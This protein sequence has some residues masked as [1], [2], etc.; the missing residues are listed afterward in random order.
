MNSINC[1]NCNNKSS[2]NSSFCTNCG[3]NLAVYRATLVKPTKVCPECTNDCNTADTTCKKCGY[4]FSYN[5]HSQTI[6]PPVHQTPSSL[7]QTNSKVCPECS[8]QN[9]I[10]S[11]TCFKCGFPFEN[12][13]QV[14]GTMPHPEVVATN[15]QIPEEKLNESKDSYAQSGNIDI[16]VDTSDN[17]VNQ[18]NPL[19]YILIGL[20][21]VA[22][23]ILA[24]A[25][26]SK[27]T[28]SD[29]EVG[30][31]VAETEVDESANSDTVLQSSTQDF[32]MKEKIFEWEELSAIQTNNGVIKYQGCEAITN[33]ED[34]NIYALVTLKSYTYNLLKFDGLVWSS[35]GNI[36]T[37]SELQGFDGFNKSIIAS[38]GHIYVTGFS[39]N[40][41]DEVILHWDGINW[42]IINNA[43]AANHVCEF[44]HFN[45]NQLRC[46]NGNL[47]SWGEFTNY[48]CASNYIAFRE[49]GD[50]WKP[51]IPLEKTPRN[52][53]GFEIDNNLQVYLCCRDDNSK[54]GGYHYSIYKWNGSDLINISS[55]FESLFHFK[56]WEPKTLPDGTG[57]F[58][59]DGVLYFF[60]ENNSP[61]EA[62][63]LLKWDGSKWIRVE[64]DNFSGFNSNIC[65][66]NSDYNGNVFVAGK[67]TNAS[68]NYYLAQ[69]NGSEWKEVGIDNQIKLK[70]EDYIFINSIGIDRNGF[71]Y[72]CKEYG[73]IYIAKTVGINQFSE[74]D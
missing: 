46:K 22:A 42:L 57:L 62:Y 5:L 19:K 20:A 32:A 25:Y 66:I 54:G 72:T 33:D 52:L 67:F 23:L 48:S 50:K 43:A 24:Y 27:T 26:Y 49:D 73:K 29:Q 6:V 1:P 40:E 12:K 70:K 41:R 58:Y 16:K 2:D 68:N 14:Q 4:P 36:N 15:N 17:D 11:S 64:Q 74:G 45:S 51:F 38:G 13:Q 37:V 31:I 30:N 3:F 60:G 8:T 35:V 10:L 34:G 7:S 53:W 21:L 47:Y 9:D 61:E 71:I 63:R 59:K 28:I 69:W 39:K 56:N 18:S 55:D 65:T 44:N